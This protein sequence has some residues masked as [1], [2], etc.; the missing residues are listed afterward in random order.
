[1][2]L[3][4]AEREGAE[5]AA[6]FRAFNTV[7]AT[8]ANRVEVVRML[9]PEEATRSKV[10][11][12]LMNRTYDVLHF[13]GHCVYDTAAPAESGWLFTGGERLAVNEL[14]RVDRIP[15]FVF[16]N[17]CE[18][19]VTGDGERSPAGLAPTFAE[20]FFA[21]G[22]SNFVCTAW[23]V[24]DTAARQFALE[25]YS[26]LLGVRA[27]D[28]PGRYAAGEVQPMYAAMRDARQHI[29]TSL[30]GAM[31]WG[32]YQHYGDPLLRLFDP[33][34]MDERAPVRRERAASGT[35]RVAHAR[36]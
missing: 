29:W 28:V 19:G 27:G 17:A 31:T 33:R 35:E 25:L 36:A 4:E 22:V 34:H 6:L 5:V 24:N 18:S 3:P 1:M 12:E 30:E 8:S 16:S 7:H 2:R 26:A 13:A 23:P 20:A 11:R 9:G 10:L 14:N 15:K 21:R 32:A